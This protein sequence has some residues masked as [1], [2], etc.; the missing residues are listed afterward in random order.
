MII[1][2]VPLICA[3]AF[4][5]QRADFFISIDFPQ[6]DTTANVNTDSL[7]VLS[8]N[9][10]LGVDSV[11]N[12]TSHIAQQLSGLEI[13]A[14]VNES[15]WGFIEKQLI[16]WQNQYKGNDTL[17][18]AKE[19]ME[20]VNA[21]VLYKHADSLKGSL[22]TTADLSDKLA[23]YK[24]IIEHQSMAIEKM[25]WLSLS[26]GNL[27]PQKQLPIVDSTITNTITAPIENKKGATNTSSKTSTTEVDSS[28]V[29]SQ[30]ALSEPDTVLMANNQRFMDAIFTKDSLSLRALIS[31]FD[32]TSLTEA[33]N[34]YRQLRFDEVGKADS[35]NHQSLHEGLMANQVDTT[36]QAINHQ[37]ANQT[38]QSVDQFMALF[39]SS[40][41]N[42]A[43][44]T[45]KVTFVVQ[46]AACREP[47]DTT[48]L[49]AIY[50]GNKTVV[51]KLKDGWHKYHI[52][53]CY[54]YSQAKEVLKSTKIK[55]AFIVAYRNNEKLTL[56]RVLK[57]RQPAIESTTDESLTFVVQI[58]ASR[59]PVTKQYIQKKY[60]GNDPW[61]MVEED[62]W[63]K[64]QIVT[65]TSYGE[66]K[67][68]LNL[69]G[70][71]GAFIVAY[72]AGERIPLEQAIKQAR[73]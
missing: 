43:T 63:Y 42:G 25:K 28:K 21:T 10:I 70:V 12:D 6:A 71:K 67:N 38:P 37:A 59:E 68:K 11:S 3:F 22:E 20:I 17:L 29:E 45:D 39:N 23:L 9:I 53:H 16:Q 40:E 48:Y 8:S 5:H 26:L 1:C 2:F 60:K 36:N 57:N 49:R 58:V 44:T 46:I 35:M 24:L 33:W 47:L 14:K 73:N 55:G 32:K 18:I 30:I 51:T 54:D 41:K 13:I 19:K 4:P 69:C 15:E 65:G 62:N 31:G 72:K 7:R 66:A 52:G 64:Y 27:S 56:W 61:R 50:K 34:L